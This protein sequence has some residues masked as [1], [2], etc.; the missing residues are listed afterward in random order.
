[1]TATN[2]IRTVRL[3]SMTRVEGEAGL[4]IEVRDGQLQDVR[5]DI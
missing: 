2:G 3:E 5:L 1:M 4:R